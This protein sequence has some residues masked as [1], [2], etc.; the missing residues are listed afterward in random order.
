VQADHDDELH[1]DHPAGRHSREP[2]SANSIGDDPPPIELL[3]AEQV[4]LLSLRGRRANAKRATEVA[5]SVRP[6]GPDSY[7]AALQAVESRGLVHREGIARHLVARHS[8]TQTHYVRLI[9]NAIATPNS[10]DGEAAELFVLL[11]AAGTLPVA[12]SSDHLKARLR[13]A[14][15]QSLRPLPD[16]VQALLEDVRAQTTREL[17]DKLLP[18]QLFPLADHASNENQNRIYLYGYAAADNFFDPSHGC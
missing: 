13:I 10:L 17:A 1:A 6:N 5:V 9:R 18:P 14:D 4:V 11:A 15:L 8:S 16:A 12:R 7:H 2:R 3:L